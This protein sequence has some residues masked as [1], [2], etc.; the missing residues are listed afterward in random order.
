MSEFFSIKSSFMYQIEV[1]NRLEDYDNGS[2][3]N[4]KKEV[5]YNDFN[6]L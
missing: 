3:G 4:N 6:P 1:R 5:D 2:H